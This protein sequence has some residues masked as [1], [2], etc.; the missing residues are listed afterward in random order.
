MATRPTANTPRFSTS[1]TN[2]EPSSG[3][4]AAGWLPNERVPAQWLN[5]LTWSAGEWIDYA[6]RVFSGEAVTD[7]A[8][9]AANPSATTPVIDVTTNAD[10]ASTQYKLL[11]RFSL[12]TTR[13]VHLYVG[14]SGSTRRWVIVQNA[15][16][17]GTQWASEDTSGPSAGIA[18][19]G[20]SL[21]D[22]LDLMWHA[23]GTATWTDGN[24]SSGGFGALSAT[25]LH[26]TGTGPGVTTTLD[27]PVTITGTAKLT[28]N[29]IDA[30]NVVAA[31]MRSTSIV[32]AQDMRVQGATLELYPSVDIVHTVVSGQPNRL[33]QLP[34]LSGDE[35]GGDIG[36]GY[37]V[38]AGYLATVPGADRFFEYPVHIP[39]GCTSWNVHVLQMSPDSGHANG[40]VVLKLARDFDAPNSTPP[41][42]ENIGTR[43]AGTFDAA[44]A[45]PISLLSPITETFDP[46][47]YS[48]IVRVTIK[49]NVAGTNRLYGVRL[50]FADPGPRNG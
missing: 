18:L 33:V 2:T 26:V 3:K 15:R 50:T 27:G 7:L 38:F 30:D 28:A 34:L 44:K 20:G 47:A 11:F 13:H 24:W 48:Y 17:N 45:I 10:G 35:L 1:G 31:A 36:V 23:A 39:R 4:K 41:I 29:D 49:G 16:W 32:I 19:R 21:S 14:S 5:W 9:N 25:S 42:Y 40:F 6:A 43:N 22:V 12:G 46:S 37:D 8:I